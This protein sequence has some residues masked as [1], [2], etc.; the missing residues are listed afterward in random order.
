[1][2]LSNPHNKDTNRTSSQK[3]GHKSQLQT[4]DL[5][6]TRGGRKFFSKTQ[7]GKKD[8]SAKEVHSAIIPGK[9]DP[10]K[11]KKTIQKRLRSHNKRK[12]GGKTSK[13][14][15]TRAQKKKIKIYLQT[16]T[17]QLRGVTTKSPP[18]TRSQVPRGGVMEVPPSLGARPTSKVAG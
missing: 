4:H 9:K 11:K 5:S 2:N 6:W 3:Q 16:G 12:K 18:R 17:T 14:F 1:M 7:W 8:T 13:K 10:A 15:K